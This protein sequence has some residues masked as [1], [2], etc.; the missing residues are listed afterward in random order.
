MNFSS[1]DLKPKDFIPYVDKKHSAAIDYAD[2][3]FD[4][5]G[6][7]GNDG[8]VT[9]M[10]NVGGGYA[11]LGHMSRTSTTLG[12]IARGLFKL[13]SN[14]T[15]NVFCHLATTGGSA[16]QL[17]LELVRYTDQVA[18]L[19]HDQTYSANNASSPAGNKTFAFDIEAAL[20]STVFNDD[21]GLLYQLRASTRAVDAGQP[22]YLKFWQ[23]YWTA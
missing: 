1:S 13:H 6:G 5:F 16:L 7:G 9:V 3:L 4:S 15:L 8:F 17:R 2:F 11:G 12:E 18:T 19:L 10:I 23:V 21:Q 14:T 22:V 20:G